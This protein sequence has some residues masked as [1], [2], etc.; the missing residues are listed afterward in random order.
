MAET[1]RYSKIEFNWNTKGNSTTSKSSSSP[2]KKKAKRGVFLPLTT[3]TATTKPPELLPLTTTTAAATTATTDSKTEATTKPLA[4]KP[5]EEEV[6]KPTFT[7]AVPNKLTPHTLGDQ[8]RREDNTAAF[9]VERGDLIAPTTT[10]SSVTNAATQENKEE[11]SKGDAAAAKKLSVARKE[12]ASTTPEHGDDE[13]EKVSSDQ[14]VVEEVDCRS[15]CTDIFSP[16][17]KSTITKCS[18]ITDYHQHCSQYALKLYANFCQQTCSDRG[19]PLTEKGVFCCPKNTDTAL[20]KKNHD[21]AIPRE[22]ND[23][24][25]TQNGDGFTHDLLDIQFSV[26]ELYTILEGSR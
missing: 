2:A 16:N 7:S 17:E 14:K 12:E 13:E 6:H 8:W 20:S 24:P 9:S 19:F 18:D 1:T 22:K 5:R 15:H 3:T 25:A 11:Q 21:N 23:V 4:L 10:A 26:D